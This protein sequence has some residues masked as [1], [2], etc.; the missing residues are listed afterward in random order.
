MR[1]LVFIICTF[2]CLQ[3]IYGGTYTFSTTTGSI[4]DLTIPWKRQGDT[5]R[6]KVTITNETG[7]AHSVKLSLSQ[8]KGGMLMSG[9]PLFFEVAGVLLDSIRIAI[10]IGGSAEFT[11]IDIPSLY[12]AGHFTRYINVFEEYNMQASGSLPIVVAS[13]LTLRKT[14]FKEEILVELKDL[15]PG[16]PEYF[17]VYFYNDSSEAQ[18]LTEFLST[19]LPPWITVQNKYSYPLV[20]LPGEIIN[21]ANAI[22][23]VKEPNVE[24][25]EDPIYLIY[26][27]G[28]LTKRTGVR[29]YITSI[30]D[31]ALLKPCIEFFLDSSFGPVK[32]GESATKELHV[33]S[34]RPYTIQLTEPKLNWGDVEGFSFNSTLFPLAVPP[35]GDVAV[36]VTFSPHTVTPLVKYRYAAGFTAHAEAD[37]SWCDPSIALA[38]IVFVEGD[39]A[40]EHGQEGCQLQISPNP[41]YDRGMVTVEG[42]EDPMIEI[43]NLL[44]N[45]ERRITARQ[46]QVAGLTA[47]TYIVRVTGMSNGRFT[48][49]SK[50]LIIQ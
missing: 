42:I 17:P 25:L 40:V 29:L 21:F 10:G 19:T 13:A 26:K 31:T 5:V 28:S 12:A 2:C 41:I 50:V 36:P 49:L 38:G 44:G 6:I 1:R 7:A 30:T 27:E 35:F 48:V 24:R 18:V 34:N 4:S 16:I 32:I 9:S 46:M 47:G 8:K 23:T 33:K 22:V 45:L 11:L 15:L 43:T 3:S 37:S 39:V 20:V 14:D